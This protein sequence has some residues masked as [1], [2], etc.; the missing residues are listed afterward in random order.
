MRVYRLD[1]IK[2]ERSVWRTLETEGSR[3][4]NGGRGTEK[5]NLTKPALTETFI[6]FPISYYVTDFYKTLKHFDTF[7]FYIVI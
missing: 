5:A 7:Y 4:K 3:A 1:A 6:G 2:G